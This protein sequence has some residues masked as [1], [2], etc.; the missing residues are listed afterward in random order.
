LRA[1]L[2]AKL[3]QSSLCDAPRF[4]GQLDAAFIDMWRSRTA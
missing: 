3:R 2:R 4:V 1:G